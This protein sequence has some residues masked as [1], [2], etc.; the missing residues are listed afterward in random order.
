VTAAITAAAD[1]YTLPIA[2]SSVLGGVKPD[3]TTLTNTSGA[4]S[5]TYGTAANTA[6]QGNDVRITGALSATTA[7]TTYAALAGATFTGTT[8]VGTNTSGLTTLNI[9][10][11]A[12][13]YRMLAYQTAGSTRWLVET[14]AVAETG[15]N[16][17]TNFYIQAWTDGGAYLSTPFTIARAT[18][19][20]TMSGGVSTS[21]LTV[22]GTTTFAATASMHVT[23]LTYAATITPNCA[24]ANYFTLTLTGN[25]TLANPSN[26]TAG[27][28]YVF[29]IAQD[30]T[31]SRTMSFGSVFKF[32]NKTAPTLTTTAGAV[33]V[34]TCF[35][36]DGTSLY[37]IL[38]TNFG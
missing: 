11:A 32:A 15:S 5:V 14:D 10:G 26:I 7:S 13:T 35:S 18:G 12:A 2:T 9:N 23:A 3:G 17:G 6:A 38:S 33:D 30:A 28:S 34:L 27:S 22:S 36:P 24:L 37:A 16:A 4:I 20:V 25:T 29:S 19:L 31:G 1:T 21:T 8:T